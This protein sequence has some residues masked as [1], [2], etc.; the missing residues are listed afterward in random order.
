[1]SRTALAWTIAA[2]ILVAIASPPEIVPMARFLSIVGLA[3]F[4]F[5]LGRWQRSLSGVLFFAIT[6]GV[7]AWSLRHVSFLG[8]VAIVVIAAGYGFVFA[9][10]VIRAA[11]RSLVLVPP[12][13][14]AGWCAIEAIRGHW[15]GAAYQHG[16]IAQSF[17][18]MP[19]LLAA[20][21]FVGE[22]GCNLLFAMIAGGL[23]GIALGARRV[24]LVLITSACLVIAVAALAIRSPQALGDPL[25]VTLVQTMQPAFRDQPMAERLR[26]PEGLY[27]HY[28]DLA[29]TV[30]D[31]DLAVW[32]EGALSGVFLVAGDEEATQ[33][34]SLAPLFGGAK[35]L[36]IGALRTDPDVERL[37]HTWPSAY[38]IAAYF[39]VREPD[40]G[41]VIR[42]IHEKEYLVPVGETVPFWLAWLKLWMPW[43]W[44]TERGQQSE[45]PRLDDGRAL[46]VA[47]CYENCFGTF[48][49]REALAGASFFAVPSFESWY[50]QGAELDQMLAMTVLRAIETGRPVVRATSDGISCAVRPNGEVALALP[51]NEATTAVATIQPR[52]GTTVALHVAGF[53]P[54]F[55]AA[56]V[57]FCLA[58]PRRQR[59]DRANGGPEG[60]TA[61]TS[62]ELPG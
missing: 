3:G 27:A 32:P 18:Q 13:F 48:F 6:Y 39:L 55:A 22:A 43:Y 14:A 1:M 20:A 50:R 57:I 19:A 10:A 9:K 16:Q 59:P 25:R 58:Y 28:R 54:F 24:S 52:Q 15:P 17:Y 47:I 45:L 35:A 46:G 30:P 41:I 34:R 26:D 29:K 61:P 23:A 38:R 49:A 44:R 33:V 8:F 31:C 53:V 12:V 42:G 40:K 21:R 7:Y 60:P 4:A 37:E 51:R 56:F 11:T 62:A 5:T 36:L 2:A